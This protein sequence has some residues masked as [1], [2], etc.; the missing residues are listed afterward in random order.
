M[1]DTR[2]DFRILG[3][4]LR[5]AH[6]VLLLGDP[7]HHHQRQRQ[8]QRRPLRRSELPHAL[9]RARCMPARTA[10]ALA[11]GTH[12]FSVDIHNEACCT[13]VKRT[14]GHIG[15][16]NRAVPAI[17]PARLYLPALMGRRALQY[18]HA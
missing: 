2:D 10:W 6:L 15:I 7:A 18:R 17:P 9:Q 4:M 3:H 11:A 13:L 1:A 16:G 12:S 14:E 8:R 5:D